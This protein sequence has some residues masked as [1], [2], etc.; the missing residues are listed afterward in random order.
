[1]KDI[2][3]QDV[4]DH[5]DKFFEDLQIEKDELVIDSQKAFEQTMINFEG[6][7][8]LCRTKKNHKRKKSRRKKKSFFNKN[9][10]KSRQKGV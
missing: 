10:S 5:W 3:A 1:L 7:S 6:S 9:G 8:R 2:T 4:H